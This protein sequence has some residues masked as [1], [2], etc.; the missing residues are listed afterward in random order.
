MMK[1]LIW[2]TGQTGTPIGLERSFPEDYPSSGFTAGSKD[3]KI[4][5]EGALENHTALE[6]HIR[7]KNDVEELPYT[8]KN[9]L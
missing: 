4:A 9:P 6:V 7:Q 3:V 1:M 5:S 2:D 8:V